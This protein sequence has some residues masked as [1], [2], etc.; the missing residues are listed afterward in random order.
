MNLTFFYYQFHVLCFDLFCEQKHFNTLSK[1]AYLL[2]ENVEILERLLTPH[3]SDND[4]WEICN[5][6]I[7][8][9]AE[10]IY[11]MI[12][13]EVRRKE[14]QCFHYDQSGG[15][16]LFTFFSLLRLF[17][18]KEQQYFFMIMATSN[19]INFWVWW[20]SDFVITAVFCAWSW[21]H[22]WKIYFF[23]LLKK[24]PRRYGRLVIDMN[25]FVMWTVLTKKSKVPVL[26]TLKLLMWMTFMDSTEK[27]RLL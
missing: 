24:K 5:I 11:Y 9:K 17:Y 12:L 3:V 16:K 23:R 2:S 18:R 27:P 1:Y 25:D 7:M 15:R 19:W 13:M 22:E 14:L 8:T 6:Y 4:C 20:K 21:R 26:W 10:F